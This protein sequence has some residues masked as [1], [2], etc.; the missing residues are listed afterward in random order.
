MI[1]RGENACRSRPP[2]VPSMHFDQLMAVV[3]AEC[4]GE[5]FTTGRRRPVSARLRKPLSPVS[6][7]GH[8]PAHPRPSS[9]RPSDARPQEGHS[10]R[11]R[12]SPRMTEVMLVCPP[13]QL[14]SPWPPSRGIT[15]AT[16][17]IGCPL[18]ELYRFSTLQTRINKA[19]TTAQPSVPY[20]VLAARV[21]QVILV[22]QRAVAY[23]ALDFRYTKLEGLGGGCWWW[24]SPA[25]DATGSGSGSE[26]R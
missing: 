21:D 5:S 4:E 1:K 19:F 8:A 13:T 3:D 18:L 15:P 10:Y 23:N 24:S 9:A 6:N 7:L 14:R 20:S 26:C 11:C 22:A 12:S 16:T 17:V 2:Q 25:V